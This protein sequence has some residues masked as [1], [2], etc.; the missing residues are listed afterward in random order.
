MCFCYFT[1]SGCCRRCCKCKD[2][3]VEVIKVENNNFYKVTYNNNVEQQKTQLT[4]LQDFIDN[5]VPIITYNNGQQNTLLVEKSIFDPSELKRIGG[6]DLG[7][8]ELWANY[9]RNNSYSKINIINPEGRLNYTLGCMLGMAIGDSVGAPYEFYP[10]NKDLYNKANYSNDFLESIKLEKNPAA[11][12]VSPGQWTDDTSMGLC[13]ADSLIINRGELKPL[14]VMKRFL[15]WWYC[16]YNNASRLENPGGRKSWGIGGNI[17]GSFNAFLQNPT[18]NRTTD[19]DVYTSGNGSIMRNAA[20]PITFNNM[21]DAVKAAE[22][23]SYVTHAG[24]EA[25]DCCKLL[26]FIC[27]KFMDG[28]KRNNIKD[29]LEDLLKDGSEVY[30]YLE[31]DSVKGLAKSQE[32]VENPKDNS[33]ENWDWKADVFAYNNSRVDNPYPGGPYIGSYAMDCMAMALHILYHTT[34]FQQAIDVASKLCGDAD[35]VAAVVGQ[36]AGAFYGFITFPQQWMDN[37][38]KYDHGEIAIRTYILSELANNI[39]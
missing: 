15:A 21:D 9:L 6:F 30:N 7:E 17:S 28:V 3:N 4:S 10:V 39:N 16:G 29:S 2:K 12:Q 1:V 24:V 32:D 35:T 19:G 22:D 11:D 13:L 5:I 18:L 31:C 8:Y 36:M 38:H 23:Q 37:L 34:S 14:D 33:P 25:A 27:L 20:I 26:T